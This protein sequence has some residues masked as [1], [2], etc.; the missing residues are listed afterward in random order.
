MSN[1]LVEKTN[2]FV[3]E[4]A[5][6]VFNVIKKVEEKARKF[7]NENNTHGHHS[8]KE[9]DQCYLYFFSN[10]MRDMFGRVHELM[11]EHDLHTL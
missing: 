5:Q 9:E 2:E 8:K 10:F 3:E 4:Q 1:D 11:D 7:F 6:D